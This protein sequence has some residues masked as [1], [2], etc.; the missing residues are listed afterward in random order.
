[1]L[2]V[3]CDDYKKK[4]YTIFTFFFEVMEKKIV[5]IWNWE[6]ITISFCIFIGQILIVIYKE[7]D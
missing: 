3:Y 2:E 1:M 7:T 4:L 6:R 5:I